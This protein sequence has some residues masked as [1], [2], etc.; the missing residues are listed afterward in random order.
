[1]RVLFT[2]KARHRLAHRRSVTLTVRVRAVGP[3]DGRGSVTTGAVLVAR[4]R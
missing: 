3:G 1:V 4:R 2:R